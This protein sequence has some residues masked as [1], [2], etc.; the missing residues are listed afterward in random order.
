MGRGRI[1]KFSAWHQAEKEWGR[2]LELVVSRVRRKPESG[3]S[4]SQ[5]FYCIVL[6]AEEGVRRAG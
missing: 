2:M 3:C 5:G 4:Q 1:L 6:R